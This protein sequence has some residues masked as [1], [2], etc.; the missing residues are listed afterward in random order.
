MRKRIRKRKEQREEE[1]VRKQK[2]EGSTVKVSSS[3]MLSIG[4]EGIVYGG[5]TEGERRREEEEDEDDGRRINDFQSVFVLERKE[6][7]DVAGWRKVFGS[8]QNRLYRCKKDGRF[9]WFLRFEE[10]PRLIIDFFANPKNLEILAKNRRPYKT[11]ID[12]A[13]LAKNI[14][15]FSVI[16]LPSSSYFPSSSL[17]PP[18]SYS[19]FPPS[20]S[21]SSSFAPSSLL[22]RY[23]ENENYFIIKDHP[24]YPLSLLQ[25]C[26]KPSFHLPKS[27]FF[28]LDP[29]LPLPSRTFI[30]NKKDGLVTIEM[31]GGVEWLPSQ[32]GYKEIKSFIRKRKRI[33]RNL[34]F[35][36]QRREDEEE[37]EV[38]IGREGER[39]KDQGKRQAREERV[40]WRTK[41]EEGRK[42]IIPKELSKKNNSKALRPSKPKL[43]KQVTV[44]ESFINNEFEI[45]IPKHKGLIS[46][47]NNPLSSFIQPPSSSPSSFFLPPPSI[48]ERRWSIGG[49]KM[50]ELG[51]GRRRRGICRNGRNRG[52]R[53]E[54]G[55]GE[56]KGKG[57]EKREC[58]E[59]GFFIW[60]TEFIQKG[61]SCGLNT[62]NYLDWKDL[63][64]P[65]T[66]FEFIAKG[67]G[68]SFRWLK[69]LGGDFNQNLRNVLLFV[70]CLMKELV[71]VSRPLKCLEK[72]TYGRIEEGR[73]KG[74][75]RREEEGKRQEEEKKEEEE[76]G[77]RNIRD[78]ENGIRKEKEEFSRI[79]REE[80]YMERLDG[81]E[82]QVLVFVKGRN[83]ELK[84]EFGEGRKEEEKKKE[85]GWRKEK[86]EGRQKEEGKGGKKEVGGEWRTEEEGGGGRRKEAEGR[87]GKTKVQGAG[88]IKSLTFLLEGGRRQIKIKCMPKWYIVASRRNWREV[89]WTG[90][91]KASTEEDGLLMDL[92]FDGNS[93]FGR[94][95]NESVNK[96]EVGK[97][98]GNW[99][100]EIKVNGVSIRSKEEAKK[101]KRKKIEGLLGTVAKGSSLFCSAQRE[102]DN[103]VRMMEGCGVKDSRNREDVLLMREGRWKEAREMRERMEVREEVARVRKWKG[104]GWLI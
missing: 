8:R 44:Q 102:E 54:V 86:E 57:D 47:V 13:N 21:S 75:G 92:E 88:H 56:G 81:D 36:D 95:L 38:G 29:S 103:E 87:K 98:Y 59:E 49:E 78:E 82:E 28:P 3:R 72:E 97:V 15:L 63:Y 84:M 40:G 100:G 7:E 33:F 51:G 65:E 104:E 68:K 14:L 76:D 58:E 71:W 64:R 10:N 91:L 20:S 66:L 31:G 90:N 23:F 62:W 77:K 27:S 74:R 35:L 5:I 1:R 45:E 12:S 6:M 61:G 96:R 19:S 53:G 89:Q 55:G 83:Y 16:S 37:E 50:E 42:V 60:E 18:P 67:L 11:S 26:S 69:G 34:E 70:L 25:S 79:D 52:G 30:I 17:P 99:L 43:Q 32:R 41:S 24:L 48:P 101:D 73:K 2:V 80:I 93:F 22:R 94:I 85:E 4:K 9:K 39:R 46:F